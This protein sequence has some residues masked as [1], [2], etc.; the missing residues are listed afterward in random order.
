[1]S[2]RLAKAER[3]LEG[4]DVARTLSLVPATIRYHVARGNI[5]PSAFTLR[6]VALYTEADVEELRRHLA[7]GRERRRA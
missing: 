6:G 5:T 3:F 4:G 7:R 1:M 2:E